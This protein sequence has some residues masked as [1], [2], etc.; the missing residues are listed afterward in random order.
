MG[1]ELDLLVATKAFGMGID[2]PNI[3]YVVHFNYPSSIESY[4]QE[5]GRGG[6]DR[7]LVLGVVLFNKQEL[8]SSEKIETVDEDGNIETHFEETNVS[9]DKKLL[10]SFHSNNFKGIAKEKGDYWLNCL[11]K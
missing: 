5:A 1:N 6:R 2:K 11:Q 7:K 9:V 4:Y 3:R 8:K 10:L